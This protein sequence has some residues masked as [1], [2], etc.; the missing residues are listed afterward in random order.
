MKRI[1]LLLIGALLSFNVMAADALFTWTK[2]TP[3][4]TDVVPPTW[5]IDEYRINCSL[6]TNGVVTP[7][8]FVVQGYDTEEFLAQGLAP[9]D[10]TCNMTSFSIGANA[11]SA[12][13]ADVNNFLTDGGIPNPPSSFDFTAQQ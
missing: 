5:T 3:V 1:G 12:P 10:M 2:P 7:V 8:N 11:E 4:F 9:G 6:D 13:T